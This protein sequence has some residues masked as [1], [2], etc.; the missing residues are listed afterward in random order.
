MV[1][2]T[3]GLVI[4][5][6]YFLH[7]NQGRARESLKWLKEIAKGHGSLAAVQRVDPAMF[8]ARLEVSS[9]L[10]R[11][12]EVRVQLHPRHCP[13]SWIWSRWRK[14]PETLQIEADL[15]FPPGVELEVHNHRWQGRITGPGKTRGTTE[16]Q[17]IGPFVLTTRTDWQ[18]EITS[19]LTAL[20]ASRDCNFLSVRFSRTS[21]NFV[22]TIPLQA[23]SPESNS[24]SEFFVVLNE[25]ASC[26]SASKF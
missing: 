25:L 8:L 23:L 1:A 9:V 2:V 12:V 15:H 5:Y 7:R 11:Q 17:H 22:A 4:W 20:V 26:G 14:Q 10:F 16:Y 18:R 6:L 24:A 21:P 3:A 19:M 13:F